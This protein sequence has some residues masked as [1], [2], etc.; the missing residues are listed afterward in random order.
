MKWVLT[1]EDEHWIDSEAIG[2]EAGMMV[3]NEN[4]Q[5][6]TLGTKRIKNKKAKSSNFKHR[7]D[8]KKNAMRNALRNSKSANIDLDHNPDE[9]D[10]S[11][12]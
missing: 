5:K 2:R 8:R 10:D 1:G 6:R 9:A 7:P 12:E 3:Q 4:A 11:D